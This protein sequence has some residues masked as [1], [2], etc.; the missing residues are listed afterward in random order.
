MGEG[1]E[2]FKTAVVEI[3]RADPMADS[4]IPPLWLRREKAGNAATP[5]VSR[6]RLPAVLQARLKRDGLP[7]VVQAQAGAGSVQVT[8][9]DSAGAALAL[10]TLPAG[11]PTPL[12]LPRGATRLSV[13]EAAA[14]AGGDDEAPATVAAG[15]PG[16][17]R[18]GYFP[19]H[20][21]AL[22]LHAFANGSF[23]EA[24]T[25]HARWKAAGA[26]A[27]SLRGSLQA[28]LSASPAA[29][30]G[31]VASYRAFRRRYVGDFV[32][33]EYSRLV[34]RVSF[35]TAARDLPAADLIACNAA[36]AAQTDDGFEW[37]V[38]LSPQRM[39]AEGEVLRRRL[40]PAVRLVAAT[41]DD[42][43]SGLK[44]ALGAAR[45]TLCCPLDP[46]GRPTADAVALIRETCFKAPDLAL[47]YTDEERCD[48]EGGALTGVFKPAYNRHLL[49]AA[50]YMGHL[51]VLPTP[52]ACLLG[53]DETAGEACVLDLVLRI[54]AQAKPGTIR[55][56]PRVAY[57]APAGS[58][59]GFPPEAI[60]DAARV[61]CRHRGAPV[62]ILPDGRHLKVDYA[63][64]QPAPLVSIVVP[65]RD[66]AELLGTALR[67]LIAR[68][69]YRA[70]EIVIVDNGSAEPQTLALFEE[71]KALWPATRVVR[72]GGDF[73]FPRICNAGVAAAQGELILLL[74][75][76]IEVV[77]GGWLAEM[78]ALAGL[79]ETG[80]VGAKLLYPDRTVQHAGVIVG[81]FRY[82][83]H[84][85]AHTAA[86]APGYEDRL[87]VRQNLSAVTGACL[88]IRRSV[89]D[90][91]GPLDEVRFAEDCNDVD[92]C[93][94]ARAAGYDVVFTPF[95]ELI[96]HES[97]TR[98]RKRSKT[99]RARLKAQ[100]A[101]MEEAWHTSRFL[102]PHYSPNLSR[103]S[104]YATQAEKPRGSR[105]SRSDTIADATR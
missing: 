85:F 20:K 79:P 71:I 5:G 36:L 17:I 53:I 81:L 8:V 19:L 51:V 67:S 83:D 96:H 54:A 14:A 31:E 26:A 62:T 92:L 4:E 47:L 60:A 69:R 42:L 27:R 75:N 7:L 61:L 59:P 43:A 64:P 88:L 50:G 6:F 2:W 44:A 34:R 15:A 76:D 38:A 3:N 97:A 94:R 73:N 82:A 68:T 89:W 30:A 74:N 9:T 12:F 18:L 105:E 56:V 48:D 37:V 91:I 32:T 84:W 13:A 90:A 41:G 1:S 35:L 28:L 66:R 65:T 95:A 101:R 100:R 98:G 52:A 70:Y 33:T 29:L 45:E 86:R 77:D 39:A 25:R 93:L 99:H 11:L 104:L 24:P 16:E 80:I 78:V 87:R 22:K 63:V 57:S 21:M 102:D 23:A 49:E 46:R 40:G 58:A 55:H 10:E 72:D 103:E